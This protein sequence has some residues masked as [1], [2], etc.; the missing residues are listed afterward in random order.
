MESGLCAGFT[1]NLIVSLFRLRPAA[2]FCW[3]W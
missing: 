3:R 1:C 2:L